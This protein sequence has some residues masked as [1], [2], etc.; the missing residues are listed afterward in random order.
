MSRI[1]FHLNNEVLRTHQTTELV[2]RSLLF[3]DSVKVLTVVP[4]RTK[5]QHNRHRDQRYRVERGRK[6]WRI[7]LPDFDHLRKKNES[8]NIQPDQIRQ[9][10]KEKGIAPT[11]PYSEQQAW[12]SCT[13]GIMEPFKILEEKS[14]SILDKIKSPV[15]G[16]KE[17]KSERDHFRRLRSYEG[18][19]FDLEAFAQEAK[20]VY[21]KAHRALASDD[22]SSEIFNY[23]T[24]HSYPMMMSGLKHQTLIWD[25]I[26]DIE[27]PKA[28]QVRTGELVEK[29]N[30]FGQITVR[31]H[32]K[33][34]LAIFD[35]HGRLIL[36]SPTDVREVLEYIV[37]EKYLA[38]EYGTWRVHDRIRP[39][40]RT[41]SVAADVLKTRVKLVSAK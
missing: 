29:T 23:V 15:Q 33:Q 24:E 25:Y 31:F 22:N 16:T 1:F 2:N 7:E 13:M 26:E 28:V 19:E 39:S 10:M 3:R 5:Y 21:I 4:V 34:I 12:M 41:G 35:R 11:N 8:G 14:S 9:K 30:M 40:D 38:D 6:T 36:G 17:W 18:E 37:F 27:P 20:D 32:S